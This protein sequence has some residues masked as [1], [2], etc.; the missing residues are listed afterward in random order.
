MVK[1]SYPMQINRRFYPRF[2]STSCRSN[3]IYRSGVLAICL[4][5]G[6][7]PQVYATSR[8][9]DIAHFSG[10]RNNA[11]T[12]YGLVMGLR[13]TGDK[14]QTLFTNQTLKNMLERFGL[15]L[16]NQTIRVQKHR[17]RDCYGRLAGF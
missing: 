12:G 5:I 1:E 15:N 6:L 9:K 8:I 7:A 11:L 3:Y 13:G 4:L 16:D 2:S 17:S 14:Q 10:V